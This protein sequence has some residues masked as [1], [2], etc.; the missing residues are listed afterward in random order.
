MRQFI[1]TFAEEKPGAGNRSRGRTAFPWPQPDT[2]KRQIE[3]LRSL[4]AGPCTHLFPVQAGETRPFSL[5]PG[6]HDS[7]LPCPDE[8]VAAGINSPNGDLNESLFI[9]L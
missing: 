9:F 6:S 1:V 3:A 5:P 2:V 8:N 4:L 7:M